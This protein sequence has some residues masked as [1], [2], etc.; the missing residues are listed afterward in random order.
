MMALLQDNP[1]VQLAFSMAEN[2]G[3]YALL[4]G[5][6]LSRSA[7]IKSGWEIMIDLIS[8][9]AKG[10]GVKD[11]DDW[12]L[13]YRNEF[14]EEPS[15]SR[16]LEDAAPTQSERMKLL[17]GYIEPEA[18]DDDLNSRRP[19]AAHKAIAHLV[20]AGYVRVILTTNFDRLMEIALAEQGVSCSII[21]SP[22]DLGGAEPYTHCRCQLLKLSGDYMDTRILNTDLELAEYPEAYEQH[23][24]RVFDEFGLVVSGWSGDWDIAL[25]R[26]LLRAP[27][28]RYP[29]YWAKRGTLTDWGS[30]VVGH[31]DG[32]VVET[33]GADHFFTEL[34][35]RVELFEQLRQANPD[36]VELLVASAKR[37]VA[38]EADRVRLRDLFERELHRALEQL[39]A[40]TSDD[41][42]EFNQDLFELRVTQCEAI[43]EPLGRMMGVL[44]AHGSDST[45]KLAQ[46]VVSRLYAFSQRRLPNPPVRTFE[47]LWA[48]PAVLCLTSYCV[49]L[50]CEERWRLLRDFLRTPAHVEPSAPITFVGMENGRYGG[51][52]LDMWMLGEQVLERLSDIPV[53][54]YAVSYRTLAIMKKWRSSFSAIRHDF[55]E[56][57]ML[58]EGLGALIQAE[59]IDASTRLEKYRRRQQEPDPILSLGLASRTEDNTTRMLEKVRDLSSEL[60]HAGFEASSG[61]AL[62][63]FEISYQWQAERW[64]RGFR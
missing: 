34:Q 32:R 42:R 48:Y 43:F 55:E 47:K 45:L 4:L 28:R 53:K 49:A 6:G 54:H 46:E 59:H 31:R 3:V 27:N 12:A 58:Y 35:E 38:T 63:Y 25:R 5:S 52:F 9:I 18:G 29:F 30:K 16:V 41:P 11:Q 56:T 15:Y 2:Q 37:Y 57:F 1:E 40:V 61:D 36:T 20:S 23:L 21:S 44:G 51:L 14:G 60:A 62:E 33:E 39:E 22:D 8:R 50:T 17:R 19:T 7:G 10:R 26:A 13:W 24:E 64:K